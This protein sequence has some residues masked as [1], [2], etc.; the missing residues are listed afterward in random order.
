MP[1]SSLLEAYDVTMIFSVQSRN[2]T[3]KVAEATFTER[4]EP[5]TQGQNLS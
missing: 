1:I 5:P 4:S 2:E 3:A